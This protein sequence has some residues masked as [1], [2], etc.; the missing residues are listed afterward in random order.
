MLE[1][2]DIQHILL[3]RVP[4]LTGDMNFFRFSSPLR[5][6]PGS[7]PYG[8]RYRRPRRS[9]IPS[10]WKNDGC[11][12]RSPGM[13]C[14]HLEWMRRHSRHFQ[15]SS[16]KAWRHGVRSSVTPARTIPIIGSV[17]LGG[18][19]CTRS[20]FFARERWPNR[21]DASTITK[22]AR[23][24][25]FCR[26][27][28]RKKL[29]PLRRRLPAEVSAVLL[30]PAEDAFD[31]RRHRRTHHAARRLWHVAIV[32]GDDRMHLRLGQAAR[33]DAQDQTSWPSQRLY[34][35]HAQS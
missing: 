12:W 28:K 17:A 19:S 8:R 27:M 14:A 10:T 29:P 4:A 6:A 30:A 21:P 15:R 2:D 9:L 11:P 20:P 23:E 5:G 25:R 34:R 22:S 18:R 13:D 32:S 35:L 33:H 3:T 31:H 16:G 24:K 26:L 7:R 1:F